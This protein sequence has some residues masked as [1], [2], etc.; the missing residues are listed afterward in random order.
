[1]LRALDAAHVPVALRS[2][3]AE[4]AGFRDTLSANDLAILERQR[5]TGVQPP[6]VLCQHSVAYAFTPSPV[7]AWNVGRTMFE[8]DSLPPDWVARCNDLD[9]V[10]V[11]SA[12]NVET[13]RS[14]GVRAPVVVV[15]GGI[16]AA[17]F[18]P[19]V[20][21]MSI[22]GV[23]GTVFLSVFEWRRRKGWD[24]LLRAWAD[25]FAP[26]ADVTLVLRTSPVGM[27]AGADRQTY[28]ESVIDGFLLAACGRRRHEVAPIVVLTQLVPDAQLPSL[29]TA[30]DVYVS[31]TRG[32]GWGRPFMEAMACGR[33]VIATRWSAHLA[34]MH[35]ENSLLL[36]IDGVEPTDDADMP[37]YAGHRW[38]AP[39][40]AH[41]V[42]LL[43][44]ARHERGL[45]DSLG[46]RA[47]RDMVTDWQWAASA[48]AIRERLRMLGAHAPRRFPVTAVGSRGAAP[49]IVMD[50]E[51]FGAH[52]APP[53][54]R[55]WLGPWCAD[56][57]HVTLV[58]REEAPLVPPAHATSASLVPAVR[59]SVGVRD[60]TV[61]WLRRADTAL[62]HRPA[63]GRW[64]VA[65]GDTVAQVVPAALLPVLQDAD[66]VWVP[67]E[68]ARGACLRAGV[69]ADRLQQLPHVRAWQRATSE[70]STYAR[71]FGAATVF[72]LVVG[73]DDQL[74][75]VDSLVRTWERA[76]ASRPERALSVLCS[77][78]PGDATFVWYDALRTR[79]ART[80]GLH[81]HGNLLF[82]DLWPAMIPA[83]D[84]LI[85]PGTA[86]CVP[87]LSTL[88]AGSGVPTITGAADPWVA[89][90][91]GWTVPMAAT[92]RFDWAAMARAVDE[93]CVPASLAVRA[94]AAREAA[95]ELPGSEA[96]LAFVRE[97]V[98]E[99]IRRDRAPSATSPRAT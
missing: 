65:T 31:P 39:T 29:Y 72:G 53:T 76:F 54:L 14:A 2:H 74:P 42:E 91:G 71:P 62:P 22:P 81:A 80:P 99:H 58:P 75:A 17:R 12:F 93:A 43:Q 38:A 28:M 48:E 37:L 24:V 96:M 40:V 5:G 47:R 35:D 56:A 4:R 50:A 94:M 23:R 13:F 73:S 36:D 82:D 69:A 95:A 60:V 21:P 78:A 52:R 63:H 6:F 7:A 85:V 34:F 25:A 70:T 87:E 26:D 8:T 46:A 97:R 33:A 89:H 77:H 27:P 16:D 11:P 32:E 61:S 30:A 59:T 67:H 88:A 83:L 45:R 66:E 3:H 92:G 51:L 18:S 49:T 10:W 79:A 64:I 90:A 1:M 9:E 68:A 19:A 20:P 15:P 84:V 55:S 44:R 57:D 98:A 86:P 41:L